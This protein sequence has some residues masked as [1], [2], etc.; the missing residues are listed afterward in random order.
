MIDSHP[1]VCVQLLWWIFIIGYAGLSVVGRRLPHTVGH[2]V[3]HNLIQQK[4]SGENQHGE[5]DF[6]N[7]FC[8]KGPLI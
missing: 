8:I 2:A 6:V 1:L 7:P 3:A 4:Q 5:I